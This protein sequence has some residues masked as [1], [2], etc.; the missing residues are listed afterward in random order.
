MQLTAACSSVEDLQA[1]QSPGS[2]Q[3]WFG[4]D[5]A[6]GLRPAFSSSREADSTGYQHVLDRGR[7]SCGLMFRVSSFM[8]VKP[9]LFTS[10][11]HFPGLSSGIGISSL[12]IST[13]HLTELGLL[14][15]TYPVPSQGLQI[16]DL[17]PQSLETS[18]SDSH[19]HCHLTSSPAV[20]AFPVPTV[21]PLTIIN[22][23]DHIL[24][25][26]PSDTTP[27]KLYT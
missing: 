8:P 4:F 12:Q 9:L 11:V 20:L 22:S 25:I 2:V 26:L 6:F 1:A 3:Y 16:L 27:V 19:F 15:V 18:N 14:H 23:K 17:T 5:V 21:L 13:Q 10:V 7:I 24:W